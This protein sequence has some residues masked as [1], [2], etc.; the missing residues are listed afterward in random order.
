MIRFIANIIYSLQSSRFAFD[1][2][3]IESTDVLTNT[4]LKEA[5]SDFFQREY[6]Q[7]NDMRYSL[8]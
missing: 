7:S 8:H 6:C 5:I 1:Y 4:S 2:I 3:G